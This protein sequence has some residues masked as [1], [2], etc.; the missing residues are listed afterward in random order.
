ML[1]DTPGFTSFDILDAEEDELQFLYPEISARVG[2]CRYD[3]C[4]HIKEP[5][6]RIR[7]A[8]LQGKIHESRYRSYVNQYKEIQ[9]RRK[10]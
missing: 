6:C 5:D 2:G 10:Y 9:E 4:R 3:S 7:E 8:V 1:F